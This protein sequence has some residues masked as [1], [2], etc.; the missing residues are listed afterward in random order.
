MKPSVVRNVHYSSSAGGPCVAAIITA[1]HP[2]FP[3]YHGDEFVGM[4]EDHVNLAVFYPDGGF[5]ARQGVAPAKGDHLPGTWHWPEREGGII[6]NAGKP[7]LMG[8]SGT[9]CVI[10]SGH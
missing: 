5:A 2:P 3:H 9:G 8:E 4:K 1:V 6:E 10:P 7:F